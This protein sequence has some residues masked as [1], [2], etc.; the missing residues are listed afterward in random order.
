MNT[1]TQAVMTSTRKRQPL[2]ASPWMAL[3]V[4]LRHE[5]KQARTL[6]H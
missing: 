2:Y 3:F 6:K 4:L 1:Q 5:R